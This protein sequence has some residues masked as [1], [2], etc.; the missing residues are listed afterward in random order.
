MLS[1]KDILTIGEASDIL[2]VSKKTLYNLVKTG[3]LYAVKVGREWR[4]LRTSLEGYLTREP[5]VK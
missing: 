1:E 4:I 2:K 3:E 5:V